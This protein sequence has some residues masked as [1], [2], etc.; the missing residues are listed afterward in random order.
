MPAITLKPKVK[1]P[2]EAIIEPEVIES[3]APATTNLQSQV[4]GLLKVASNHK[5]NA[6]KLSRSIATLHKMFVIPAL[7]RGD[8]ETV[9]SYI[10]ADDIWTVAS[11]RNFNVKTRVDTYTNKKG[12]T[13]LAHYTEHHNYLRRCKQGEEGGVYYNGMFVITRKTHKVKENC[14]ASMPLS[15]CFEGIFPLEKE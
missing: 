12:E 1:T 11:S 2:T 13:F 10:D 3:H 15:E 8:M 14:D 4:N 5:H 6:H 9:W 7:L